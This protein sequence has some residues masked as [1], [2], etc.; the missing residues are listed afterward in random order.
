MSKIISIGSAP[1][2]RGV[3]NNKSTYYI[4]NVV[5]MYGCVFIGL[6]NEM[7]GL[8]PLTKQSNNTIVFSNTNCWNCIVDNLALYNAAPVTYDAAKRCD[9]TNAAVQDAEKVRM[10][11]ENYRVKMENERQALID[12]KVQNAVASVFSDYYAQIEAKIKEA[13]RAI[14]ELDAT[15]NPASTTSV[16]I[17]V[18]SELTAYPNTIVDI[19]PKVF[20][21][22]SCNKSCV[23]QI[24]SGDGHVTPDGKLTSSSVGDVLVYVTPTLASGASKLVT[25]HFTEPTPLQDENS[26]IITDETGED[27]LG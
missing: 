21:P 6:L 9:A 19:S 20:V 7:S 11:S 2:F 10:Q 8:P 15:A 16:S 13:E 12:T 3:Y 26:N 24:Y 14:S 1:L 22:D 25:V 5:T 18:T 23:Y 27:I 17:F 4:D